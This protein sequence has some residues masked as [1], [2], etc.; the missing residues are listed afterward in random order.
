M[1]Q[2]SDQQTSDQQNDGQGTIQPFVEG[3]LDFFGGHIPADTLIWEYQEPGIYSWLDRPTIIIG[4]P[5]EFPR[6]QQGRCGVINLLHPLEQETPR[7]G[8]PECRCMMIKEIKE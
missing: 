8:K 4:Y 6:A 2:H 5:P 7:C 1:L 3:F